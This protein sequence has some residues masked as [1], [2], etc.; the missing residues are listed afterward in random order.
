MNISK[1]NTLY[2]NI[3]NNDTNNTRLNFRSPAP[4]SETKL[5]VKCD[6]AE[7][8]PKITELCQKS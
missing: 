7:K 5:Q 4:S 2:T 6:G 8:L 1:I 3:I